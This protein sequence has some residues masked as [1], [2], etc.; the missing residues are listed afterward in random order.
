MSRPTSDQPASSKEVSRK[1]KKKNKLKEGS[2]DLMAVE[3]IGQSGQ[4]F[5]KREGKKRRGYCLIHCIDSHD[6]VE[7][8]VVQGIINKVL[9]DHKSWHDEDVENEG[10]P[11]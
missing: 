1:E 11:D 8:K 10:D 9:G 2:S 5:E 3:Q 4:C 7:C 6:L